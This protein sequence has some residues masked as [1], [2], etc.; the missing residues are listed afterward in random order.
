M[1]LII[2][3]SG[4][5]TAQLVLCLVP[6][7]VSSSACCASSEEIEM[8]RTEMPFRLLFDH[9]GAGKSPAVSNR[10]LQRPGS[11]EVVPLRAAAVGLQMGWARVPR[12]VHAESGCCARCTKAVVSWRAEMSELPSVIVALDLLR[13]GWLLLDGAKYGCDWSLYRDSPSTSH[14]V[15]CVVALNDEHACASAP[16]TADV[17]LRTIRGL[18]RA[19]QI[20]SRQLVV[21]VVKSLETE[22]AAATGDT[23]IRTVH[24]ARIAGVHD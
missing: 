10:P 6:R 23:T 5:T 20:T 14:A 16:S 1:D 13:A 3:A 12:C 4:S 9:H 18:Q 7:D 24:Y 21:G 15:A 2:V 17:T 8:P 22:S 19:A 11:Y